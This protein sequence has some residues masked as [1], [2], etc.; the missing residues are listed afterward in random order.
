MIV[1]QLGGATAGAIT[2]F[3]LLDPD[4]GVAS[5]ATVDYTSLGSLLDNDPMTRPKDVVRMINN[6]IP[7]NPAAV[8]GGLVALGDP[9]VCDLIAPIRATLD[10]DQVAAVT[11]CYSGMTAKCVVDFYLDWLDELVDRRDYEGEGIFGNVAAGLYRLANDRKAPFVVDGLRPFPVP[12]GDNPEWPD[13]RRIEP[14]EFVEVN[15]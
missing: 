8:I 5:T 4:L 2:P 11:K 10:A 1:P 9:R 6:D 12:G 7:K 13:I 14:P 3:M 15:R